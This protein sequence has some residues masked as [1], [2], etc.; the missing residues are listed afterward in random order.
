MITTS[1]Q[2]TILEI[3]KNYWALHVDEDSFR[4]ILAG[5]EIGH[6][7]ADYVDE[8]TTELIAATL[9]TGRQLLPSGEQMPRSMG[10][11]WVESNNVLNPVNVKS[12]L[13]DTNGK[14]NL[15]ALQKLLDSLLADE[16]DSYYLLI[17]KME[18]TDTQSAVKKVAP[19]VFLVDM[20]DILDFV[21]FD[22]GPGQLMLK[23]KSFY[24]HLASG[25]ELAPRS[26]ADKVKFLVKIREDGDLRLI[27][28]RAA[29]L[30]QTLQAAKRY[31]DKVDHK[32]TQ[33][34]LYFDK[35]KGR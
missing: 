8:R 4:S 32:I 11:I 14:P 24:E 28:N 19:K 6:R 18:I 10:D 25:A 29:A 17:V 35:S 27:E 7:I 1:D 9:P 13:W 26:L 16:I 21:S 23:E 30:A 20:L 31:E 15:V 12:G 22:S 2:K 33:E 34:E 5:K 3:T